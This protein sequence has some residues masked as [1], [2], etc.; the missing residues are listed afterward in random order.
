[1]DALA[2]L[3]GF[4]REQDRERSAAIREALAADV[5]PE[6]IARALGMELAEVKALGESQPVTPATAGSPQVMTAWA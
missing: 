2:R 5:N 1:M 4:V 6:L 3:F